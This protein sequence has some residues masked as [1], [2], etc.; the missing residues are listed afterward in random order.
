MPKLRPYRVDYFDIE[1]MKDNDLALVRSVIVRAVTSADA[2]YEVM[3]KPELN[4]TDLPSFVLI[5]SY[6][7]YKNLVHKK[8][9]YKAVEDLFTAN[10]AVKIM[11]Q[12]EAYRAKRKARFMAN[13]AYGSPSVSAPGHV[14]RYSDSSL[15]DEVCVN[16]GATD[17]SGKLDQ[18]CPVTP[19]AVSAV[20]P[21]PEPAGTGPDSPATKAVV[22]DLQGM[23]AH[24][25][26]EQ[27]MDTFVPNTSGNT[28]LQLQAA[29]GTKEP[30]TVR[31]NDGTL[32]VLDPTATNE[33]AKAAEQST[34]EEQKRCEGC[35]AIHLPVSQDSHLC[36]HCIAQSPIEPDRAVGSSARPSFSTPSPAPGFTI[37]L[38]AKILAFSGLFAAA[39]YLLLHSH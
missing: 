19:A 18:P 9:V 6:R 4:T 7:F 15:Y 11:E 17:T 39:V 1:E 32:G 36:L 24:D 12:V 33:A 28:T 14:T 5:R 26:H 10:K 20:T 35:G 38:W 37:P 31:T 22:A 30:F 23:L 27:A 21:T 13:E 16:C 25:A 29:V 8:D 3:E 34:T 2:V